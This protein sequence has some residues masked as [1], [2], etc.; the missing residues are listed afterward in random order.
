[1]S[2]TPR[3][4]EK[5]HHFEVTA[6]NAERQA[7]TTIRLFKN[8]KPSPFGGVPGDAQVYS[9]HSDFSVLEDDGEPEWD[10]RDNWTTAELR[11]AAEAFAAAADKAEEM[12]R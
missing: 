12:Q 4:I 5:K 7:L 9:Y 10:E 3:I 2:T 8:D 6:Y 11:A 1:M